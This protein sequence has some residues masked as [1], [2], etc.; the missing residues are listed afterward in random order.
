MV[1]LGTLSD[2]YIINGDGTSISSVQIRAPGNINDYTN[3]ARSAIVSD[4]LY[5]FGGDG[6]DT[7][8]RKVILFGF[9]EILISLDCKARFLL[10]CRA[11][12]EVKCRFCLGSLY[13]VN[14]KRI[15]SAHLLRAGKY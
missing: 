13:S 15:R 7:S 14:F 11:R 9:M 4:K 2:S 12:S 6:V 8:Y 10:I 5:L 3:G 1:I